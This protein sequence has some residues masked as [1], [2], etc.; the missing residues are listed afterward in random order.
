M[1]EGLPVF[2]HEK[3]L[4]ESADV[5]SGTRVWAFAHVMKGA[6]IGRD[7]NICGHSFV[8]AGARL[9]DGVVVKNGVQIW[10]G[11]RLEDQVFVGPNATFTNDLRPRAEAADFE[12]VPTRV[13]RGA[14]IG[15]NATVVCGSTIGES[16]FVAAGAVVTNDVAA[17]ALMAGNPA[18]RV[19]WVCVCAKRLGDDLACACGRRY[20][21][22]DEGGGLEPADQP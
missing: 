17:H 19:G 20:R 18:R 10:D 15:A 2:V 7:C 22:V 6:V 12:L 14:S 4:C 3:G 11:V 1:G 9:G 5:G 16:A 13:R 8:E 21:L